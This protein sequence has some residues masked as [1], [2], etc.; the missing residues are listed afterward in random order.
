MER[1]KQ[2]FQGTGKVFS[3]TF[4]Q[5]LKNKGN[6]L[7]LILMM[8]MCL[9]SVPV[10]LWSQ[11]AEAAKASHSGAQR[12]IVKNDTDVSADWS[13]MFA[14]DPYYQDVSIETGSDGIGF[15]QAGAEN[16]DETV[17]F[18]QVS[19]GRDGYEISAK[20]VSGSSDE[21]E[22]NR[23]LQTARA[24]FQEARCLALGI[25]STSLDALN[26]GFEIETASVSDVEE[27]ERND[28]STRYWLQYAYAI[29]VMILSM[30]SV[31]YIV[32]AIIEEKESKLVETLMVS[33][34]P[35]ALIA[36]MP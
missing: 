3:F 13:A 14:A 9:V 2:E 35:L 16:T 29:L 8:V 4:V 34:K 17:L 10:M 7:T 24:G 28:F 30:M 6:M 32:R 27:P 36:G 5:M 1:N 18:L 33:I 11:G 20:T 23:L 25:D 22:I 31:S 26:Q 12:I 15:E 21:T 19:Q